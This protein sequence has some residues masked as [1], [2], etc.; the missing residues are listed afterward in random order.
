MERLYV[1][2]TTIT[3]INALKEREIERERESGRSSIGSRQ[4]TETYA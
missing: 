1:H 3:L 2:Q 4:K